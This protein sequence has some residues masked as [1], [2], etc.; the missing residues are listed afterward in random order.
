MV[1]IQFKYGSNNVPRVSDVEIERHAIQYLQDYNADLLKT[2]QPLDV[3]DFAEGYFRLHFHYANLSHAG[4]I[5]GRMVF[6]NTINSGKIQH[7]FLIN[8]STN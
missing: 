4:F 2:P 8:V 1:D 3:D 6:D 7:I 5:W